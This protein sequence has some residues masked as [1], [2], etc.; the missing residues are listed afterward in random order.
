MLLAP[1]QLLL[2]TTQ[3]PQQYSL[4]PDK[5]RRAIEYAHAGYSLHFASEIYAIAILA[6]I[7]ATGLS[8]KF[9]DWAEAA[10]TRRFVQ[11]LI[12]IP[13]LLVT[14]DLLYLPANIFGQHLERKFDQSIQSWPSWFWDWTKSEL[15]AVVCAVPLAW[16][17]YA[18]IRRSPRRWWL[19]F[20]LATLPIIVTVMYLEPM[21][22]EPLFY[23]F[24]P[25]AATHPAL[26]SKLEQLVARGGLAIPPDRMFEMKASEKL[27]SLNAYVSGFGGSKRVVV[28]DTTLQKLTT[29]EILFVFGHEMGHYVLGHI[30]NSLLWLSLLLL[31]LLFLGSHIVRW[32]IARRGGNWRIREPADWASLPV[33]LL[34]VAI[35]SLITEPIVNGYSRWQEHQADIFGLEITHAIVPDS[36]AAA[37][38]SFQVMGE[39]GLDEPNPNH[40]I[41][42]WLFSH[43]STSN[44]MTFAQTY[45]PWKNGTPKYVK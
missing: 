3:S 7:V 29:P 28:W 13:L 5:L 6:V 40:F 21:I 9:R 35:F 44:R 34:I 27:N 26:V 10:S 33:L 32:I 31:A 42:F 24:E 17:L 8:A 19:Y 25:L 30:R 1:I 16:L 12:F 39:I 36:S 43:P 2:L 4:P 38:H 18:V 14:N 20:W 41:E 22:I 11:A 45:D 15:I 37:A 23:R